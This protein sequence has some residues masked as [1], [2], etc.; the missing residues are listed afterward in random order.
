M[1]YIDIEKSIATIKEIL[2]CEDYVEVVFPVLTNALKHLY[3]H[4]K[5]IAKETWMFYW[6]R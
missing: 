5:K 2:N 6:F 4:L 1:N 3:K